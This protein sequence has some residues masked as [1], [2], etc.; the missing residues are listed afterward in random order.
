MSTHAFI[1]II[2]KLSTN[3]ARLQARIDS[4][5]K[6]VSNTPQDTH[7]LPVHNGKKIADDIQDTLDSTVQRVD[8][9]ENNSREFKKY[10]AS[11]ADEMKQ[12]RQNSV[13]SSKTGS[14]V[15]TETMQKQ[16]SEE[17]M[18]LKEKLRKDFEEMEEKLKSEFLGFKNAIST[19]KMQYTEIKGNQQSLNSRIETLSLQLGNNEELHDL[20]SKTDI[21]HT[22]LKKE[23]GHL[24]DTIDT[25]EDNYQK[26]IPMLKK[27]SDE[28]KD[29]LG[30]FSNAQKDM[31]ALYDETVKK[32]EQIENKILQQPKSK[33]KQSPSSTTDISDIDSILKEA[34]AQAQV[35]TPSQSDI[36]IDF[37]TGKQNVNKQTDDENQENDI[38][39]DEDEESSKTDKSSKKKRVMRKKQ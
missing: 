3:V 10:Q 1:N 26:D 15:N 19:C 30:T 2:N 12:I 17:M 11:I 37:N 25:I 23:M 28:I 9:L 27:H 36:T 35:P 32:L 8:Y 31:M 18:K 16:V 39:N 5:E 22:R 4:I 14:G 34:H 13:S 20:E 24:Q 29:N 6:N 33:E 7:V 21:M 38:P